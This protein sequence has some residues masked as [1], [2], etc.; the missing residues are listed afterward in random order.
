[1]RLKNHSWFA[2]GKLLITGEYLVL[3]GAKALAFPLKLGQR[4]S[5]YSSL[6][7]TLKWDAVSPR[8]TWFKA[9][10]KIPDL[11]VLETADPSLSNRLLILLERI[12]ELAPDFAEQ[13]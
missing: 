1:M 6:K 2:N 12:L 9:S 8:G 4:L 7:K 3:D 13:M 10:L 11:E 5:V